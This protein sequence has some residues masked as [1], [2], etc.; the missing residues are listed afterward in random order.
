MAYYQMLRAAE[1]DEAGNADEVYE[2]LGEV[3]AIDPTN[4]LPA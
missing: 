1:A 3:L 2:I 4:P